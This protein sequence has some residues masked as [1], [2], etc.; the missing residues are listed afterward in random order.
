VAVFVADGV[1]TREQALKQQLVRQSPAVGAHVLATMAALEEQLVAELD[2][3]TGGAPP[4]RARLLSNG[5]VAALRAAAETW[6][7]Q[8]G[9]ALDFPDL[10]HDAFTA[11]APAFGD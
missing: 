10:L 4:L 8:D 7:S 5:V 11:L 2:R 3:R 6:L 9:D 1:A